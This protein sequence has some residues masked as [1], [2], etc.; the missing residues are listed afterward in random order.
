MIYILGVIIILIGAIYFIEKYNSK[1]NKKYLVQELQ[2]PKYKVVL[3]LKNGKEISTN[4]FEPKFLNSGVGTI[5]P[6]IVRAEYFI[7]KLFAENHTIVNN[8]VIFL[9]GLEDIKIEMEIKK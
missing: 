4:Y 1:I 8:E 6:S 5:M 7:N 3:K 2:K 9:N